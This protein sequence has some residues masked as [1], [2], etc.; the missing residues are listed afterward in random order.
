MTL[1]TDTWPFM[2]IL[3]LTEMEKSVLALSLKV[4]LVSLVLTLPTALCCAWLLAR[5]SFPGKSLFN[6]LVH[7]P[8]VLPPVVT[9]FLLLLVF[10]S[11]KPV[12]G[13]LESTL[14]LQLAFHWTGATLAV[15][16][17]SLPLA[18]DAMRLSL[19][20]LDRRLETAAATLGA[21]PLHVFTSITLPLM[22][23]GILTGA[24]L[25]FARAIGEFGATITFAANIPGETRTLPLAIYSL[26]QMPG[27]DA[28]VL[29]LLV[30]SIAI[31]LAALIGSELLSRRLRQGGGE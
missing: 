5:K 8:L 6:G 9:G 10:G 13:W 7:L 31:S 19:E 25:A 1:P 4:S 21:S 24:I 15:A 27:N 23:P 16:I 28:A 26:A 3:L 12:G 17:V 30:I 11:S 22:L 2:Q 18:V 29:R 20:G 14:G